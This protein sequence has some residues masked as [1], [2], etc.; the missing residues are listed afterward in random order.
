ME[1]NTILRV[2]L[3]LISTILRVYGPVLCYVRCPHIYYLRPYALYVTVTFYR[4]L[5]IFAL[6]FTMIVYYYYYRYLCIYNYMPLVGQTLSIC[7]YVVSVMAA[8]AV[9]TSSIIRRDI[10]ITLLYSPGILLY[11]YIISCSVYIIIILCGSPP[12]SG[13][14]YNRL[15]T[16]HYY[17]LFSTILAFAVDHIQISTALASR[18]W[19]LSLPVEGQVTLQY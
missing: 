18:Y 19:E 16:N 13:W 8:C 9:T 12:V 10:I 17:L 11:Y 6:C 14:L 15:L 5:F 2:L 3:R 7:T 1:S 4:L